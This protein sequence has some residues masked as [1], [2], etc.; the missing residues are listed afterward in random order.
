MDKIDSKDPNSVYI[1]FLKGMNKC[2][3]IST[4]KEALE[5][6]T[7]SQRVYEDLEKNIEFGE[8]L[9]ESK[10]ILR[11]WVDEVM[12]YPQF[13]FRS[14]VHDKK[15]NALSQYFSDVR[16]DDLVEQRT[17]MLEKINLFFGNVVLK[18]IPHESFVID[19]FVSPTKG[20]MIIELNPFHIGAGAC[21]FS[22]KTDREVM[23]NGP[24]EFRIQ[25][26]QADDTMYKSFLTVQWEKYLVLHHNVPSPNYTKDQLEH[27][28]HTD[29]STNKE[30]NCIV[31]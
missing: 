22:W 23:M 6:L 5:L 19:F 27:K 25:E 11:Q 2:M 29:N 17:E 10:I 7:R 4:G 26:K 20:V 3:K 21:L 14:F 13:E 16:F 30:G 8:K 24:Q 28:K 9:Y 31:A 18:H 15:L 1:A 12:D